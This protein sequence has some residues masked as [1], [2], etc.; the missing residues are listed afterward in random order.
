MTFILEWLVPKVHH[1]HSQFIHLTFGTLAYA[2]EA[3][4]LKKAETIDGHMP[5][6]EVC[7]EACCNSFVSQLHVVVYLQRTADRRK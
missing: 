7:E 1:D 3:A 2:V 4:S 6:G 5:V